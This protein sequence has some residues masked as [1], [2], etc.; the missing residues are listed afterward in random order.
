[1][2]SLRR[3]TNQSQITTHLEML[4]YCNQKLANNNRRFFFVSKDDVHQFSIQQEERFLSAKGVK[5][6]RDIHSLRVISQNQIEARNYSMQLDSKIIIIDSR[7]TGAN[8]TLTTVLQ[9]VF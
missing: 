8:F 7:M 1:M 6:T 3:Q 4:E 2:E 5:G 9:Y